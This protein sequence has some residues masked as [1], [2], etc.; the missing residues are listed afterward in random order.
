MGKP[1]SEPAG[2]QWT[3]LSVHRCRGAGL[4]YDREVDELGLEPQV[5]RGKRFSETQAA[6]LRLVHAFHSTV[7][8]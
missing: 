7:S 5:F 4:Q 1:S 6:V 3:S 2:G 8:F